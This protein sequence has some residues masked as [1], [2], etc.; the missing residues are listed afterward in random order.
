MN[1]GNG[2]LWTELPPGDLRPTRSHTAQRP[3][4]APR[5]RYPRGRARTGDRAVGPGNAHKRRGQASLGSDRRGHLPRLAHE[6]AHRADARPIVF[7]PGHRLNLSIPRLAPREGRGGEPRTFRPDRGR[8]H[9]AGMS[10]LRSNMPA[11]Q[12][13]PAAHASRLVAQDAPSVAVGLG[14]REFGP[15]GRLTYDCT[16]IGTVCIRGSKS[17][18]N[19]SAPI[20]RLPPTAGPSH[21]RPRRRITA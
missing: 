12:S 8:H 7:R 19:F 3:S 6:P 15:Q 2:K 14:V 1:A 20:A 21:R 4:A 13:K 10:L 9:Q 5:R 16:P 11:P 17:R 18:P